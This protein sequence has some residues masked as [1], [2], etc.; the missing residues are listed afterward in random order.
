M[1]DLDPAAAAARGES[2]R[3]AIEALLT[4]AGD[5]AGIQGAVSAAAEACASGAGQQA[6]ASVVIPIFEIADSAQD[7]FDAII[8]EWNANGFS[9]SDRAMGT[10][11]YSADDSQAVGAHRLEIRGNTEGIRI[12]ATGACIVAR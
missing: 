7:A 9:R 11:F 8:A 4:D 3:L 2:D 5:T 1:V 10:D 6:Q 12:A